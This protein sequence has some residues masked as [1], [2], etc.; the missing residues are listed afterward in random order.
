MS[1]LKSLI[2]TFQLVAICMAAIIATFF[3]YCQPS[4]GLVGGSWVQ[5]P[6]NGIVTGKGAGLGPLVVCRASFDGGQ[7]PGK[8]WQGDCNF[9]WGFQDH[10]ESSFEVLLDN[11]YSW[12]KPGRFIVNNYGQ[13]VWSF[14]GLP[15]NAVDGGD[16]G[17]TAGHTRL[18]ICQ[19]YVAADNTWHPGKLYANF[20]NIA[21]GGS[22]SGGQGGERQRRQRRV[23][24]DASGDVLVLVK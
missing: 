7:H 2:N 22:R 10:F 8:L 3:V 12:I 15:P 13:Q 11:G 14:D 9:E 17:N 5:L 20:C 4:E 21:W 24:L 18:G 16:A 19:A 6:A 23:E 1:F